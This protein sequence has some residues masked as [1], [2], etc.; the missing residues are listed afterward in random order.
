MNMKNDE[1]QGLDGK[2]ILV[3]G[4]TGSIGS[5]IVRQLLNKNVDVVRIFSND[6]NSTFQIEQELK[7][8][9][10]VRFLV[11][12]IR[13][14]DRLKKA[15]EEINIVYNA[16]ALKHVPLC[17]YN[18]FEAIKTNVTGTQN[19]VDAALAEDVE[20]VISISTDKAVNP[21]NTMGATKL[22][23][24]KLIINANFHKGLKKTVFSCVR[25]GNVI[26]SRGS[27]IPLFIE[28]IKQGKPITV[29]D[30]DMTRY[31]LP[32]SK[33][34]DL[35]F[36]ATSLAIGGEIFILKMP[37][38]R[39]GDVVDLLVEES[40]SNMGKNKEDIKVTFLGPRPGEKHFE[41]LMTKTEAKRAI[42]TVAMYIIPPEIDIPPRLEL[43]DYSYP[44]AKPAQIT[45]YTSENE[46]LLTKEEIKR[47]LEEVN[48]L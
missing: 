8:H 36:K 10:N 42:E 24:E 14:K 47:V 31:I 27:A 22:L 34:V 43:E 30:P 39:M 15:M 38:I 32:I 28:Q 26:P 35:V 19:I 48:L 3:T 41:E 6:E 17:E 33:A 4:G 46:K 13:D 20:K 2:K 9:K 21:V 23:S 1:V 16:A 12:D 11:G 44:G 5:A 45:D 18:P 29:T 25:F 40:T 37:V 7:E